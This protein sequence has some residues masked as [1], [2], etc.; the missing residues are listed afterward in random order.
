[1]LSVPGEHGGVEQESW[2]KSTPRTHVS[3]VLCLTLR[4]TAITPLTQHSE[5]GSPTVVKVL[6]VLARVGSPP[7]KTQ[8]KLD[9]K[10]SSRLKRRSNLFAARS[11]T[12]PCA[13]QLRC[14]QVRQPR[15]LPCQSADR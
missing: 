7:K 6:R 5:Q 9:L 10:S 11:R 1:M 13:A 4:E 2:V 14:S 12:E 8:R 3:M 15:D